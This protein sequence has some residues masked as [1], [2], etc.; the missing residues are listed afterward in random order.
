MIVAIIALVFATTGSAIAARQLIT[1]RDIAR[2][3]I[4]ASNLARSARRSLAGPRGPRGPEGA[5]GDQGFPGARGPQGTTGER[6]PA[7]PQGREGPQGIQG[8]RGEPG[9]TGRTG[10][11]GPIGPIGPQGAPGQALAGSS[12]TLGAPLTATRSALTA[13]APATDADG[14]DL[15]DPN[16]PIVLEFFVPYK[17]DILVQARNPDA[18][19]GLAYG[20]GRLFI[21]TIPFATVETPAIPE[22]ATNV[23]QGSG[24]FIVSGGGTFLLRGAVRSDD[25]TDADLSANVIVTRIG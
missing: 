7:G 10:E 18:E 25:F 20:V 2:G 23:A 4:T 24:S 21:D 17:V 3:T 6:G 14:V 16:T 9:P 22:D 19:S 13:D 15:L 1:G 8:L 5:A 11:Q 12:S